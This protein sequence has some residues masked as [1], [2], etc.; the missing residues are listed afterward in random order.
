MRYAFVS[1]LIFLALHF[2]DDSRAQSYPAK[3]VRVVVPTTPGSGADV[4]GRIVAEGL[5]QVF[6]QQ[7]IVENRGG[8]S[9]NIGA[10]FV[11]RAPAD[12]Y[13]LLQA[14]MT[15]AA[16]VSLFRNLSYDLLRDFAAVTL[17]AVQPHIIVVHPSMPV[18]SVKDLIRLAKARP[19]ALSYSSAGAGTTTHLAAELFRHMAG[20]DLLHVP[21]N[22]GGPAL[23]AVLSGEVMVYFAPLPTSFPLTR[24]GKLRAF[25]VTTGE[26]FS[27][28][29]EYPSAYPTIAEAG[30]LPGYALVTWYGLMVPAKPPRSTITA[31]HAATVAV[32]KKPEVN[33]RLTN[34]AY[35]PAG[36]QPEEFTAR[37]KADIAMVAGIVQ[38]SGA[39]AN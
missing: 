7:V 2:V 4:I 3:V 29:P 9:S 5:T 20:V 37:I 38:R 21:Y 39:T 35:I 26:P 23:T 34:L 6:G 31:L 24:A 28:T 18:K 17:V 32:L 25:A 33:K 36:N 19:G 16:N 30:G 12:G 27:G 13:T 22:G 1:L 11:A 8:A 14:S 15:L 10:E